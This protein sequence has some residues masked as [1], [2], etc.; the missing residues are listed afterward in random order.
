MLGVICPGISRFSLT[1]RTVAKERS[2]ISYSMEYGP[3]IFS[4]DMAEAVRVVKNWDDL[5]QLQPPSFI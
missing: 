4:Q 5:K 1:A 2:G 3:A